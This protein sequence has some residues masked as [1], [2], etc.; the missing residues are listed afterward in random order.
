MQARVLLSEREVPV[1]FLVE[2]MVNGSVASD[3]GARIAD[4]RRNGRQES[5]NTVGAIVALPVRDAA[6]TTALFDDLDIETL[7][8]KPVLVSVHKS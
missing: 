8:S 4:P 3:T 2:E 7:L 5:P 6:T 1:D